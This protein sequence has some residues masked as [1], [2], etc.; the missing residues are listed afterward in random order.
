MPPD[1]GI[2]APAIDYKVVA[3]GLAADGFMDSRF[4]KVVLVAGTHRCAKVGSVLLT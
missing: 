3:F 1:A 2:A 4:Q